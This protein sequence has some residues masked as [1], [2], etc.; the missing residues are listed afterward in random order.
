MTGAGGG[1]KSLLAMQLAAAVATG[2]RR[3]FSAD[4]HMAPRLDSSK[5]RRVVFASWEDET[6]ELVRRLAAIGVDRAAMGDRFA[7][8]DMAGRGP[9]WG[10][11]EGK[12][13]DTTG[14][15]TLAG[16]KLERLIRRTR[17][18]L[19]VID[20][21]AAAFAGSEN[22]RAAVRAWLS[23]LGRLAADAKPAIL[24][25]AHPPKDTAH[26]FSG[27]TDWRGGVR[28]LWTLGPEDVSGL[29][30]APD[31]KGT[32]K[33]QALT[34]DK[35]NYAKNGRRAWLRLRVEG[36]DSTGAL[37]QVMRWEEVS[38]T[39]SAE[40]YHA[41]KG[42]DSPEAA[43]QSRAKGAAQVAPETKVEMF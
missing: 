22:D 10:P 38:K 20:P 19:V 25:I 15:L 40:A 42:W 35:S 7:F 9:I 36:G 31:K 28:S 8:V 41:W 34:L 5:K 6:S 39:E 16:K 4:E 23:H 29:T 24:L 14:S 32:A 3:P 1:G 43:E 30:G 21:T 26:A 2:N 11:Q 37:P 17:P 12:H 18:A 13:R 33:G 27:S